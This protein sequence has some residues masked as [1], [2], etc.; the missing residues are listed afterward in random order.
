MRSSP[1]LRVL[2]LAKYAP[3]VRGGMETTMTELLTAFAERNDVTVDCYCYADRSSEERR[4]ARV[5]LRRRRVT[6]VAAS[7]PLSLALLISYWRARRDVDV[8]LSRRT[9]RRP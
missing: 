6:A 7:A 5:R 1:N 3:P 9:T 8:V 4:S 2:H